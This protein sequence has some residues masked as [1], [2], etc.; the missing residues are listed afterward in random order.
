MTTLEDSYLLVQA[1]LRTVNGYSSLVSYVSSSAARARLGITEGTEPYR[2]RLQRCWII[3]WTLPLFAAGIIY[4]AWT[5]SW[6]W[7]LTLLAFILAQGRINF[8]QTETNKVLAAYVI[9][10]DRL[11]EEEPWRST[12]EA[13]HTRSLIH[14]AIERMERF[15]EKS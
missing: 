8:I 2:K 9:A 12:A 14:G 6:W 15:E 3:Q 1:R 10:T 11:F 13:V 5:V 4:V 7:L